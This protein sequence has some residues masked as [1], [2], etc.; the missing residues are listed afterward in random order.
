MSRLVVTAGTGTG[1]GKTH[2]TESLALCAALRGIAVAAWKP[3][4]TGLSV[5]GPSSGDPPSSGSTPVPTTRRSPPGGDTPQADFAR[6]RAVSAFHVQHLLEPLFAYEPPVSPH[7][8]ARHAGRPIDPDAI[9]GHAG[10]LRAELGAQGLVFLELPGGLCTPLATDLL[11]LDL[12][13]RLAPDVLC[14][15]VPDRLG[16]LHDTLAVWKVL[17]TLSSPPPVYLVVS[18]PETAD[19]STGTNGKELHHFLPTTTRI[20]TVPRADSVDLART[21]HLSAFIDLF[22]RES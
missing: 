13:D 5:G 6:L 16:A 19:A 9:V 15:V 8:A 2:V 3:V 10:R 18:T 4:E 11:N 20:I 12:V 14:L 22:L 21:A 7:L 1:I 17:A